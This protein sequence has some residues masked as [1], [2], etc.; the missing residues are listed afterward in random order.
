MMQLQH[1]IHG[2]TGQIVTWTQNS[3]MYMARCRWNTEL[4]GHNAYIIQNSQIQRT[5]TQN[6]WGCIVAAVYL[7]RINFLKYGSTLM[8]QGRNLRISPTLRGG[9]WFARNISSLRGLRSISSRGS[10]SLDTGILGKTL[11]NQVIN[12]WFTNSRESNICRRIWQLL[13]Q[14]FVVFRKIKPKRLW[15]HVLRQ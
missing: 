2:C 14:W 5:T 7:P 6:L 13:H 9:M 15:I 1:R 3:C 12:M 8:V 4:I 10:M 11:E